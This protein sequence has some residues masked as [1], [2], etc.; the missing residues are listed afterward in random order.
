MTQFT[1]SQ[2]T[3]RGDFSLSP[4]GVIDLRKSNGIA[5]QIRSLLREVI[6]VLSFDYECIFIGGPS[7]PDNG[8]V[9]RCARERK[10]SR[11]D[12]CLPSSS[13]RNV[14][15]KRTTLHFLSVHPDE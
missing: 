5:A 8:R 3:D 15:G 11:R 7:P 10:I 6:N 12:R 1:C 2:R 14:D 4:I 13:V 9:T